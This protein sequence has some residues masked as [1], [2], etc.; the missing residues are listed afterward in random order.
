MV[1]K[2]FLEI[3]VFSYRRYLSFLMVCDKIVSSLL[4]MIQRGTLEALVDLAFLYII[5]K[6]AT[7][8]FH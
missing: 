5:N 1:D 3:L 7:K 4:R 2:D 8:F 6:S